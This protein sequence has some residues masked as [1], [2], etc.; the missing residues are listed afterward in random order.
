MCYPA[1]R[2]VY[3]HFLGAL[4][5]SDGLPLYLMQ[6]LQ[7]QQPGTYWYHS[8][9]KSQ[10]PDGLRGML[11]INDPESPYLSHYDEEIVL[12]L[13]DWYHDQ[14]PDL[15]RRYDRG[16]GMMPHDPLP[17]ANLI[18]DVHKPKIAVQVGKTYLVRLANI[19]AFVGQYFW[20][21]GH[22][23]RIV[24]VDGV[25]TVPKETTCVYL[26]PGQRYAFLLTS[27]QESSTNYAM[28]ARADLVSP[29]NIYD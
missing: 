16:A 15:L 22:S 23:M 19:G 6:G 1:W 28:I 14:M 9:T 26:S 11:V 12:S 4:S 21:E 8:H 13:S 17:N 10:Y 7:V 2:E 27:K 29:S 24:E 5:L 18:N 3:V 25:Y 20:I